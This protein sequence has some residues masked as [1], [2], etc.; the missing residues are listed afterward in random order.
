M[1]SNWAFRWCA[2][3]WACMAVHEDGC[4]CV[5]YTVY[6]EVFVYRRGS[7]LST[8]TVSLSYPGLIPQ[9][10]LL[11]HWRYVVSDD[12]IFNHRAINRIPRDRVLLCVYLFAI[13]RVVRSSPT[14]VFKQ[15]TCHGTVHLCVV[16]PVF[17]Y[18]QPRLPPYVQPVTCLLSA[19]HCLLL[20]RT[21]PT[22]DSN[23]IIESHSDFALKC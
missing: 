16:H 4:V 23:V 15:E 18:P 11:S 2:D 5:R 8:G 20:L 7:C 1:V 3:C 19:C 6:L 14:T 10:G 9:Y 22:L 21:T 12:S 13:S 17:S